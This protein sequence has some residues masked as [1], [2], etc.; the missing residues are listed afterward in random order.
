MYLYQYLNTFLKVYF[1]IMISSKVLTLKI[2]IENTIVQFSFN[3]INYYN[4]IILCVS[5]PAIDW[6]ND[7]GGNLTPRYHTGKAKITFRLSH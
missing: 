2:N 7:K 4:K 6:E 1:T 3:T 5:S